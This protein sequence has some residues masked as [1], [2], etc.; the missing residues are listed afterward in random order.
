VRDSFGGDLRPVVR[1]DAGYFAAE[2]AHTAVGLGC[3]FAVAA[4]RNPAM[5]RATATVPEHDWSAAH[6]MTGAQVAVSDYA[7]AGWPP[8]TYTI[9]RRVRVGGRG[10]GRGLGF[11]AAGYRRPRALSAQL[12]AVRSASVPFGVTVVVADKPFWVDP[13]P[14]PRLR[15]G[16]APRGTPTR[17]GPAR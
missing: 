10:A 1:A 16:A 7:P 9:I 4:R 15:P 14:Y 12:E 3:D 2:L 6:R 11:L 17:C 8:H 5:W 13:C